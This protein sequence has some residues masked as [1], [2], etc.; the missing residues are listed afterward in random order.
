MSVLSDS[1]RHEYYTTLANSLPPPVLA[2][3]GYSDR[4]LIAAVETFNALRPGDAYEAQPRRADRAVR[5]A[6]RRVP[7]PGRPLPR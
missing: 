7:A 1:A 4:R 6:C 5:R 3:P 2:G